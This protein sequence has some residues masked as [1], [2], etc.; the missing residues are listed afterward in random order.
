MYLACGIKI[1]QHLQLR[2][3]FLTTNAQT[4]DTGD[5]RKRL[6][7]FLGLLAQHVFLLAE[8]AHDDGFAFAGKHLAHLVAQVGLHG[9]I[10]AGVSVDHFPNRGNRL[11]V[12]RFRIDTDPYLARIDPHDLITG[13]RASD[14]G[15][16]SAHPW[17][18]FQLTADSRRDA[19][20]LG[21]R[22]AGGRGQ[23]HQHPSLLERRQQ[24]LSEERP[25]RYC[26]H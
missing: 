3:F 20:S 24:R 12:I 15:A 4:G 17:Y 21:M 2:L 14:V 19:V 16:D 6:S 8:N 25:Y 7:D 23:I 26:G 10:N 11:V 1:D 5:S 22:G 18:R 9:T 13:Y